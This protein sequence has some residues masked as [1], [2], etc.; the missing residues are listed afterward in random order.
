MKYLSALFL[1]ILVS[2]LVFAQ[3]KPVS[4][5][6][7]VI[8]I[9]VDQMRWDFL[10]RYQ[11][12]YSEKG[13]KKLLNNGFSCE[14]TFIPYSQTITAC[15]HASIYTGSVPAIHG[16][17]GNNWWDKQNHRSAYCTEDKTVK[18]IGSTSSEGAMSP[19]NMLTTTL[20]D[21]LRLSTNFQSKSIGIAIKDRGA[22]LP[23]GHS[24]NAA[25]WYDSKSGNFIS[26]S[27]YMNEI[28]A[29]VKAFNEQKLPDQYYDKG[30]KTLYPLESYTQ[31]TAD[32]KD[33]ENKVFGKEATGF[34]YNL[35]SFKGKD[36]SK[37]CSTPHGNTI[38]IEMAKAAIEAEKLGQGNVTDFLAI[39][40]SSTDYAGHAYGPNSIE[41]EDMY[42][43]LDLQLADF[44]SY[45]DNKY[46][47]ENYLLFLTADHGIAHIPDFLKGNKIPA[48]SVSG[49][50]TTELNHNI[51]SKFG[52]EKPFLNSINYQ[53]TLNYAA[54]DSANIDRR[55]FANYIV[56]FL[57][58]QEGI[59]RV[60]D[61][62]N[63]T[64]T[65]L[66]EKLKGLFTNSYYPARSGDLQLVMKP[67]YIHGGHSGA[68]H[69]VWNPYDAHIPLIWYGWNIKPGQSNKEV[70]M[71]DIAPTIAAMLHIQMPSGCIGKVIE[72]VGK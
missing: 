41:T 5:P 54:V 32:I 61:L 53:I 15:G 28:P 26:S 17:V 23:A 68:S 51:K 12:R 34:P 57:E 19:R 31:S 13:F 66:P 50:Y 25:Y 35:S 49:N 56:Q 7:I 40:F 18:G 11:N 37:L 60:I 67:Q 16:I 55:V 43:Q 33:Y 44:F 65:T 47:K 38:T 52:I 14:N 27:Y 29:W 39:S 45:L 58:Q 24:A 20:A 30:W 4:K 22:I 70:Y 10:Y 21:E 1:S 46:G 2:T 9:V 42:L 59:T 64:Q 71:T 36:Y 69:G 62:A 6:K 3:N 63:L 72:E 48:G 8:G